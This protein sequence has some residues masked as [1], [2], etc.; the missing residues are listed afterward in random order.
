[1]TH[2][3][4][5]QWKRCPQGLKPS[6]AAAINPVTNLLIDVLF[7]WSLLH[8]DD[9][10]G[11]A[12]TEEESI[13]R[14]DYILTKFGD[15]GVTL[16]W[17]KVWILLEEAEY[18]SHVISQG[19]AFP[20]PEMCDAIVRIPDR[21]N[22]VK[23][24]QS[25][26]G[27]MQYF[28]LYVPFMA[29]FR[30]KLTDLTKKDVEFVFTEVH[31]EAVRMLKKLL[32]RAVV[33]LVDW[34][35]EFYVISDASGTSMA[36]CLMQ[37]HDDGHYLPLRFMSRGFDKYEKAQE[38]REREMRAGWFSMLKSHSC[39]APPTVFTWMMDHA[40]IRYCMQAKSEH[41]R[42]ARLALWLSMYYYNLQHLAGKHVLLQIVDCISR[43]DIPD[44]AGDR[45]IFSPFEDERCQNILTSHLVKDKVIRCPQQFVFDTKET[46]AKMTRTGVD[47]V[48]NVA[49]SM[50]DLVSKSTHSCVRGCRGY[51]DH[52]NANVTDVRAFLRRWSLPV[53]RPRVSFHKQNSKVAE[54]FDTVPLINAMEIYGSYLTASVA[55][56]RSNIQ[57]CATVECNPETASVIA[58][59]P[60]DREQCASYS[61]VEALRIAILQSSVELPYISV[62]HAT[63]GPTNSVQLRTG[64]SS[65]ASS[66]A[67]HVL[68]LLSVLNSVQGIHPVVSV[69]FVIPSSS[70]DSV[71]PAIEERAASLMYV[72]HTMS[73]RS[74]NHGDFVGRNVIVVALTRKELRHRLPLPRL[75]KPIE[76]PEPH[77]IYHLSDLGMPVTSIAKHAKVLMCLY[78]GDKLGVQHRS[79]YRLD[80]PRRLATVENK[81]Y[82]GKFQDQNKFDCYSTLAPMPTVNKEL[83][84]IITNPKSKP[85]NWSCRQTT[86]K[87]VCSAYSLTNYMAEHAAT[88][89]NEMFAA[90]ISTTTPLNILS[91]FYSELS[92]SLV[93]KSR[94]NLQKGGKAFAC[95]SASTVL[96]GTIT[97]SQPSA[98]IAEKPLM[99]QRHF[100][101]NE[102]MFDLILVNREQW[103]PEFSIG[104]NAKT[105]IE[106]NV[107]VF[108][109]NKPMP[110]GRMYVAVVYNGFGSIIEPFKTVMPGVMTITFDIK[111]YDSPTPQVSGVDKQ[112]EPDVKG[113]YLCFCWKEFIIKH[114]APIAIVFMPPCGPRSRQHAVGKHYD[115]QHFPVSDEAINADRCV[116]KAIFDIAV[117]KLFNPNLQWLIENPHYSKFTGLPSV[118]PFMEAGEYSIIQYK[119]YDPKFTVKRT[120]IL[121][122]L[123][124]WVPRELSDRTNNKGVKPWNSSAGWNAQRRNAWP[125]ELSTDIAVAIRE[126]LVE[127]QNSLFN[128]LTKSG[129]IK[130]KQASSNAARIAWKAI[131]ELFGKYASKVIELLREDPKVKSTAGSTAEGNDAVMTDAVDDVDT[132]KTGDCAKFQSVNVDKE[133]ALTFETIKYAQDNDVRIQGW[134]EVARLKMDVERLEN[135]SPPIESD[136]RKAQGIH[137]SAMVSLHKTVRG[138]VQ[139]MYV[140]ELGLLVIA[141][142]NK[143]DPIP[144]ITPELGEVMI[145]LSHDELSTLHLGSRKM[146]FW[147]IERC[148]WFGMLLHIT[149]HSKS[150]LTCQRMKFSASPGYGYQQMRWYNGPGKMICIDLVVL[151]QSHASS[152]GTRYIFTI[153]DSFSHYPDAYPLKIAEAKDCAGCILK[154]CAYNGVPQQI[155]ADGGSNLNVSQIFK[156]LYKMVGVNKGIVN[157]A[158]SPQSNTVERF[159]RWLGAAMR[160]L[161]FNFNLDIDESLPH[162]L[163]IWR[164]TECRVTGFTPFALHCG[165]TMRFP[166]DLFEKDLADV[167]HTEYSQHLN[168]LTKTIWK[169]ARNAQRIAQLESAR[170]YNQKHSI[171]KDLRV[172]DLVLRQKIPTNPTDIPSHMLPRC[173]GP[174]RVLKVSARGAIIK[175]ATTGKVDKS[176]LRHIR[177]C[178]VRRDDEDYEPDGKLQLRS[179][180]YVI[181][182]MYPQGD[183]GPKWQVARLLHQTP[184]EDSWVVQWCNTDDDDQSVRIECSFAP[185]WFVN[186]DSDVEVYSLTKKQRY[187]SIEWVVTLQRVLGPSFKLVRSK[188]PAPV[189]AIIKS[190]FLSKY[191]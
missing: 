83:P 158:Y 100:P 37:K 176:S 63:I 142:A 72:T 76:C 89:P 51:C 152:V 164:A 174:Y 49:G 186:E 23:E 170:Y 184:D 9:L 32:L 53:V 159:H 169:Q 155:R 17:F 154:W 178:I 101:C 183:S 111:S 59:A 122:G 117:I 180:E 121:H 181:V 143:E 12:K 30:A 62:I 191:W 15:F 75:E 22:N 85:S 125:S 34:K 136:I 44:T 97:V 91:Q 69:N 137:H 18:V 98:A 6:S 150:C 84:R 11:W 10:L 145:C 60:G 8:C 56:H 128:V 134:K 162:V 105:D 54:Q 1:M 175:H 115:S 27:C 139:H 103:E 127:G 88:L 171:K 61:N 109:Y 95:D 141:N 133:N 20:S 129:A 130:A 112:P 106:T 138:F 57:V 43:L 77:E 126:S 120:I 4:A 48:P 166:R 110:K 33:Y 179:A 52:R 92:A 185:A 156:E 5:W 135:S 66:K 94:R 116:D 39:V 147:L 123:S 47:I 31:V 107:P 151:T 172:G 24:V 29:E 71:I 28:A 165:R 157:N 19:K 74:S 67:E 187:V 124:K 26:V 153:L 45:E 104:N 161:L 2:I 64:A 167:T 38:N 190:R 90:I 7:N 42:I 68:K 188:L 55:M 119:D 93:T 41:Q 189:K 160:I 114:G 87:E 21:L 36:G 70:A 14:F 35:K 25:F 13:Q 173:T 86:C 58:E 140:N 65:E 113:D 144:V 108:K 149:K 132:S 177:K 80:K 146:K 131:S 46:H 81:F 16:G 96:Y 3:G 99:V 102:T 73:R 82:S 118:R 168:Q 182:R 163:W 79:G 148:W 40:N 50:I 78:S